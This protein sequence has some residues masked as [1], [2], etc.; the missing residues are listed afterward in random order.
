MSDEQAEMLSQW[1]DA[2]ETGTAVL[3]ALASGRMV[4][5]DDRRLRIANS[6]MAQCLRELRFATRAA[7]HPPPHPE[8]SG[9][10]D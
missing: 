5:V 1:L 3:R 7:V 10:K 2:A 4:V 6:F 9:H 8:L